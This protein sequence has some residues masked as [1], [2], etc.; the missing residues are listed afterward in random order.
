MTVYLRI[1]D[2]SSDP[3]SSFAARYESAVSSGDHSGREA[4]VSTLYWVFHA[5]RGNTNGYQ[6]LNTLSYLYTHS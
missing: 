1:Y 4:S 6:M 2:K 3:A 5:S